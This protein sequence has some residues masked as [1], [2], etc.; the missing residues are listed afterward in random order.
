LRTVEAPL[1]QTYRT[2]ITYFLQDGTLYSDAFSM[3]GLAG[4]ECGYTPVPMDTVTGG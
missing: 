2:T 1:I 3:P 4:E